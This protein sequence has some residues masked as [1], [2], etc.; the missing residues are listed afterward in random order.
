[1]DRLRDWWHP[2][3][4]LPRFHCLACAKVTLLSGAS[5]V[6]WNALGLALGLLA[7]GFFGDTYCC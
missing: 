2:L 7:L 3:N 4:T 6:G 5:W 1:M